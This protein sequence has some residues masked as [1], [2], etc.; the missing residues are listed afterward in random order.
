VLV[1]DETW[2]ATSMFEAVINL[3]SDLAARVTS[4]TR[5]RLHAGASELGAR[6][7]SVNRCSDSRESALAR[8]IT[9]SPVTLRGGD[10]FVLRLPAPLRTIGGGVV[11]D[12]YA[13]RRPLP[14]D[15]A[16][17]LAALVASSGT[18][19][20]RILGAEGTRG[21]ATKDI[22]VRIGC[23][24]AE[25]SDLVDQS[26]AFIGAHNLFAPMAVEQVMASVRRIIA[27]Y[28]IRAPLAPGVPARTLREGLRTN[29]ELVEIA[30]REMSAAGEIETSGPLVSRTGWAPSPS[31]RDVKVIDQVAH[32]ICAGSQEPPSVGELVSR[33]G[34]SVPGLLRFLERQGRIVQVETDRYYDRSALEA[35][36]GRLKNGLVPGKVYVPAQL[37]DVLGFSRKYLIPFLEFCDRNGITERRGDGRMLRETPGFLLDTS[38]IQS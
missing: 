35:M 20:S 14:R 18:R 28:E 32:D 9:N 13:R 7:A 4:R 1:T 23:T 30:I 25:V 2:R 3:D 31:E 5:L 21:I 10:R 38:A 37:R 11:V 17:Q 24:P 19:F 34:S 22:P 36:I 15:S 8:I 16:E 29:E 26:G 33:Y 27:E 6:L 12:P